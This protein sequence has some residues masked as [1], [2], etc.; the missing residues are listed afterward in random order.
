MNAHNS[1][2]LTNKIGKYTK[3][4]SYEIYARVK[5][6]TLPIHVLVLASIIY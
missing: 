4:L 1:S 5:G 6:T 3:T 2:N